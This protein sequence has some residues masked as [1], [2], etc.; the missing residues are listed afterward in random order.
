[1]STTKGYV[2][3]VEDNDFNIDILSEFVHQEGYDF[4]AAKD[5]VEA[6][7]VLQKDYQKISFILL[8]RKMPNMCGMTLMKYINEHPEISQIPVVMQTSAGKREEIDDAIRNARVFYYL[9]KPY[10]QKM[11]HEAVVAVEEVFE[12]R[13][14]H[15]VT[16]ET[17]ETKAETSAEDFKN[18]NPQPV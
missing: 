16:D 6:W 14:M 8:D 5:G 10:D 13:L 17:L 9:V 15:K 18:G 12:R 7:D 1:M 2:L 11:F 3:I 4:F